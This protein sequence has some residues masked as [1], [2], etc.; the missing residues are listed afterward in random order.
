[1]NL[2]KD[3]SISIKLILLLVVFILGYSIF[4]LVAFSTLNTLRSPAKRRPC[5]CQRV[6]IRRSESPVYDTP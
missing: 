2:F 5:V 3:A 1:M 6:G 4:G